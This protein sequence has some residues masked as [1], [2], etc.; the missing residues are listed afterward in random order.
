MNPEQA[1]ARAKA[2]RR[3]I[4]RHNHAYYVLDAP[5]VP[6]AEYDRLFSELQALEAEHPGLRSAA[7]P[8]QRVGG[9][10]LPEFAPV[11]HA[12]PMLSIRT[13]TD[14]EPSGARAFDA[15]VRRELGLGDGD[16]PVDYAVE[17][18]FDGLA[19]NLRYENG[20][21]VQ[22]A[23]RGDGETGED[24]TQ[25]IRTV[26]RIPLRLQGAVPQLLEVRGEVFMSRPDFESYNEKQRARGRATLVNPRNGAAGSIRQLDPAM[27]AERPLSFYA[28]G[29]GDTLGWDLPATHAGVLDALAAFGLPVCEHRAV[30]QGADGLIGF[31]ARMRELR[32]SLP[33]DIDGVVYKVN[34][35]ALQQQLGFVTREPRWAVAHKYPAE[36]ALTT[37]EAIEVQV[38]RTGA[39]TPVARLAPVFVGGVT[40]TNATLHN[41]AEARRKDVRSGDTVVV[42]RAGDVIPEVVS[43]VIERRPKRALLGDEALHPAFVLPKNCPVCGSAI[44]RP[45]DEAIARCTGGLVCPAQRKQA[46]LHFAGRRAMDIEGLGDKLVEQLVDNAIVKTPA[47]FYK[48]GL[49]AMANLER[50]AEKSAGNLLAAIEKSKATTLARF[51]FALGIRNVGE[52]TAKDLARFFGNLDALIAADCDRLQQVPDVGPVVAASIVHFFAE[53]H[54]VEVIEQLR[55]AGVNWP[56]GETVAAVSSPV[57]GKTFVLTGTLPTLARNEAKDMIEALGGKVAGS[58]SKKTDYVVAGA[59]AGSKLDKARDLEVTI[60]DEAQFRELLTGGH[61]F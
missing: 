5:T 36:E 37:V 51:I 28:Y 7:S 61:K 47:D 58:V 34:S 29:L 39:I 10:P 25:N 8:T 19:I 40:V 2:L 1:A 53:P 13:E 3:K 4:E 24:V 21:L 49:L 11:R 15:R 32:D 6:D 55:A 35:L 56:E 52:A 22:A 26:R 42:R 12:V 57:A 9:K 50:M 16:A 31:H 60:L 54:N 46:L 18:K 43:V 27:A 38:G 30:V 59:E 23:T 17:L 48:L 41:E 44:E 33:F 14:T 45:E 20:V